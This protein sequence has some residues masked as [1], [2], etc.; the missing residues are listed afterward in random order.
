MVVSQRYWPQNTIHP[1]NH[2]IWDI[3]LGLWVQ[4]LKLKTNDL[5]KNV[6]QSLLSWER[7]C[8]L[9]FYTTPIN[10]TQCVFCMPFL[11]WKLLP[12]KLKPE[13][14]SHTRLIGY[15]KPFLR[16]NTDAGYLKNSNRR[17]TATDPSCCCLINGT[18]IYIPRQSTRSH[19][20]N[21]LIKS[22]N[23]Q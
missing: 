17:T 2:N 9:Q 11:F 6:S 22:S 15:N 13:Q 4:N 5:H 19:L 20:S 10:T 12:L 21:Y 8:L 7:V 3:T 18:I 23:I 16:T 1:I 14:V